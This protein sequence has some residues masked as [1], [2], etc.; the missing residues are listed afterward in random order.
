MTWSES[1]ADFSLMSFASGL[2]VIV[3]FVGSLALTSSSSSSSSSSPSPCFAC[4]NASCA[5]F[6][7]LCRVAAPSFGSF[8][9]DQENGSNPFLLATNALRVPECPP[10]EI[11]P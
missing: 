6:V 9:R 10:A 3:F 5:R 11:S 2:D 1:E 4:P 8:F 7:F